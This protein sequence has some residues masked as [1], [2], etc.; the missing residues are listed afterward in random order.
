MFKQHLLTH[1]L[2]SPEPYT[3]RGSRQ[4]R[5]RHVKADMK[6]YILLETAAIF[7]LANLFLKQGISLEYVMVD[8]ICIH[9]LT[10]PVRSA[11]RELQNE[12]FLSTVEFEPGAFRL[13]SE[14]AKRWAIRADKYRSSKGDRVLPE[15]FM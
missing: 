14:H 7:F 9:G 12:K 8:F 10:W 1:V 2:I 11:N 15:L 5:R 3:T 13:R 6:S 4:Q